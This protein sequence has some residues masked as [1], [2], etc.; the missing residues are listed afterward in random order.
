MVT[1][2]REQ[3]NESRRATLVPERPRAPALRCTRSHVEHARRFPNTVHPG[4]ASVPHY[5]ENGRNAPDLPPPARLPA[6]SSLRSSRAGSRAAGSTA[7]TYDNGHGDGHDDNPNLG[8]RPLAVIGLRPPPRNGIYVIRRYG[9]A[10]SRTAAG[11]PPTPT[12]GE[13]TALVHGPDSEPLPNAPYVQRTKELPITCLSKTRPAQAD[14]ATRRESPERKTPQRR[15]NNLSITCRQPV[16]NSRPLSKTPAELGQADPLGFP[17]AARV[18][19][20][21]TPRRIVILASA[22]GHNPGLRTVLTPL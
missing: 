7:T 4:D 9:P 20:A 2:A 10:G 18:L 3:P 14:P 6:L 19:E 12:D 17:P 8:Q 16:D 5:P 22:P 1:A 15:A 11:P 13:R 21:P